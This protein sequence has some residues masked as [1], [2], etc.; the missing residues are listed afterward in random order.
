VVIDI[1]VAAR[2]VTL[3]TLNGFY[4]GNR[5]QYLHQEASVELVAALEGST[6]TPNLDASPGLASFDRK[7]SARA[8]IMPRRPST[9]V[10]ESGSRTTTTWPTWWRTG[11]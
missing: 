6:W 8:A 2:Q 3:D 9:R 5:V 4:E 1:D 10:N 11:C 7:T